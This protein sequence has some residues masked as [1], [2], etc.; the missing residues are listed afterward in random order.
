MIGERGSPLGPLAGQPIRLAD[1]T[2]E[3]RIVHWSPITPGE[4]LARLGCLRTDRPAVLALNGRSGAGKSTIAARL[5]AA[6]PRAALI[7]TDDVAWNHSMFDWA[8]HL[9]A[10]VIEPALRGAAVD[11]RPPGWVTH[12][13][14]G[15]LTVAPNRSLLVVEGVGSSQRAMT[16]VLDAA[17]WVQSDFR[18][19]RGQGIARDIASGVNGDEA[20][21][22]AFWD[23]WMQSE[24]PF[25]EAD[26]PWSRADAYLA[27]V[28]PER[29][30]RLLWAPGPGAHADPPL[31]T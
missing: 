2:A 7:S 14:P 10:D 26:E 15:S 13:R 30:D 4:L 1:D 6:V 21:S 17:A 22:I 11:Y 29:T 9:I 8:D 31:L 23:E 19:A 28:R 18:T 27:G 24:V 12:R 25:M 16:D 3:P 5:V 20:A